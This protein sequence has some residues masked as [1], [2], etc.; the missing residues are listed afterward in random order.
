MVT[1]CLGAAGELEKEGISA[2][3]VDLRTISP[4]DQET[5][6]ASV[7]K[8]GRA[9][10]AHEAVRTFGVGAEIA[11]TLQE[12]LFGTLKAPVRRLGAPFTP[13]PFAGNLEQAF[14]VQP[15]E[16]IAAAKSTLQSK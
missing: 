5:V 9:V 16:I 2:E 14:L 11:A 12:E 8:T 7:R 13:V 10:V 6:L 3:V 4:W 15:A 1:R